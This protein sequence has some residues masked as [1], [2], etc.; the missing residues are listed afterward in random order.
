MRKNYATSL[1]ESDIGKE[2]QVAGW[3]NNRRDHGGIIFIESNPLVAINDLMDFELW[4][5]PDISNDHLYSFTQKEER[6]QDLRAKIN[7]VKSV[8]LC[9]FGCRFLRPAPKRITQKNN[10]YNTTL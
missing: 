8:V 6:R 2:V 10:S 3:V 5:S 1:S 4:G 9:I 7:Y